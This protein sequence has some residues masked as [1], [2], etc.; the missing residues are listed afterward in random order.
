MNYCFN[1]NEL[2]SHLIKLNFL[3]SFTFIIKIEKAN[4][5]LD[6]IIILYTKVKTVLLAVKKRNVHYE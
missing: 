4:I 5:Q 6:V 2:K 1:L 3:K